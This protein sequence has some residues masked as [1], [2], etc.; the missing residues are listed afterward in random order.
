MPTNVWVTSD[1]MTDAGPLPKE[2]TT[3]EIPIFA[4][5]LPMFPVEAPVAN[6]SAEVVLQ[7]I[8][9]LLEEAKS[10]PEGAYETIICNLVPDLE[11]E[12]QFQ[13]DIASYT[14]KPQPEPITI[15]HTCPNCGCKE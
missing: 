14:L 15:Q 10:L 2:W 4:D 5:N 12:I 1:G 6:T 3:V 13:Q 11:E 9:A 7:K 8:A